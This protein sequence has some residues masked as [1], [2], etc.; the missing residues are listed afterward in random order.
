MDENLQDSFNRYSRIFWW[1]LAAVVALVFLLSLKRFFGRDEFEAIHTGW[2]ILAGQRVYTDFFQ[3]HHPFFYY[4]LSGVIAI[5]GTSTT[6]VIASRMLSFVMFALIL[7]V[8]FRLCLRIY[9]D[10][11]IA[12]ISLLMLTTAQFFVDSA[13]EVRPDVPQTLFGLLA[14]LFIFTY[15]DK[16]K[17][18]YLLLSSASLAISFLILQKAVFAV[19]IMAILL[20]VG[21][22]RKQLSVKDILL[23]AAASV[24]I[25]APY[26]IYL[27]STGTLHAYF[28]FNWL[29]NMRF[30]YRFSAVD[31]F[32]L[33]LRTSVL[34]SVFYIAALAGFPKTP[35]RWRIEWISLALMLSVFCVRAPFRQ[36]FML[37]MSLAAIVAANA[38]FAIFSKNRRYL[39]VLLTVTVAASIAF[40]IR[41]TYAHMFVR[42]LPVVIILAAIV[43]FAMYSN[44]SVRRKWLPAILIVAIVIPS[45][46]LLSS[47]AR[48]NGTQFAAVQY[49]LDVT[50]P[51][52]SVYDGNA[53]FNLFR[54]DIDFFLFS[55]RMRTH[56]PGALESY[57]KTIADYPYDIY[58]LIDEHKPK[59][60]WPY[61][62]DNMFDS[63]IADNYTK[64]KTHDIFYIRND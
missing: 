31:G 50:E 41:D 55:T 1:L 5:F 21:L 15:F 2:L 56:W 23:Y 16:H 51:D 37:A 60:I 9:K 33:I 57:Q 40:A 38:V 59:V 61:M 6:S 26:Y 63:R 47:L 35:S 20:I 36:Y 19:F 39:A 45:I 49:V 64:S 11:R 28:T 54:K 7:L 13:I 30:L 10:K 4:C 62:I 53:S 58:Q 18:I 44:T 43:S 14:F 24:V 34:L 8:T 42:I 17:T 32:T 52:D 3:H 27:A 48:S 46:N 12:L 22:Y 29:L 25:V